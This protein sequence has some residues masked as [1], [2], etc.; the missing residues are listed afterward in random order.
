MPIY[1]IGTGRGENVHA[2]RQELDAW[3]LRVR[4]SADLSER[5]DESGRPAAEPALAAEEADPVGVESG[6]P[7]FSGRRLVVASA[8]A[9]GAI[10]LVVTIIVWPWN[11]GRQAA[12]FQLDHDTVRIVD[13]AGRLVF[14]RKFDVPLPPR[15]QWEPPDRPGRWLIIRD[16]D[17][18]GS[19]ETLLFAPG[20][21]SSGLTV[22]LCLDARGQERFRLSLG[23]RSVTFGGTTY[24]A[25]W[26]GHALFVTS[27]GGEPTLWVAWREATLGH[28]P[29]L[30]QR[31]GA[32]GKVLSEYWSA[33]YITSVRAGVIRGVRSILV[34]AANNDQKGA[35]L[36]VFPGERVEGSAP[37]IDPGKS[38]L[39]CGAGGPADFLIFPPT[40]YSRATGALPTVPAINV[41]KDGGVRVVVRH[42][43]QDAEGHAYDGA[44]DYDLT[45]NLLPRH[46]EFI[47]DY[48]ATH[49]RLERLK[50][51]DHP[52]GESDLRGA[53][54]VRRLRGG[55]FVAVT[56]TSAR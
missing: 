9:C 42:V 44:I 48:V 17:G 53:W 46:A 3:L 45:P 47:T 32:N 16:L 40:E 35:S 34:G 6:R 15:S 8:L 7:A 21:G 11:P 5:P 37:A 29:C 10:A 25:P 30:L 12:D 20:Q 19:R 26:D 22:L 41:G 36:A 28:F 33:G 52:F 24:S 54:P 14:Q 55:V 31:V 51:L 4:S 1:R 2:F 23:D 43:G 49:D 38:C 13:S 50:V 39:G 18:D 56:G 27:F